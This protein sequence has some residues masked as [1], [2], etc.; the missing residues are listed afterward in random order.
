[1]AQGDQVAALRGGN[2]PVLARAISQVENGR[3]GFEALLSRIHP[4][5]GHA[6]R[7]G[8]TGPPGAG[9]STLTERLVHWVHAAAFFVLLG[10]GLCLYLPALTT[11]VARRPL[12]VEPSLEHS[13]LDQPGKPAS[14]HVR[15]D[16]Q[17][18]LKLVEPGLAGEGVAKDQDAPP[19]AHL[20]EAAGDRAGHGGEALALHGADATTVTCMMKASHIAAQSRILSARRR[21]E[22]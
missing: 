10:S 16:A 11:L 19:L 13:G 2:V 21:G 6:R 22:P 15:G 8:I 7:I 3:A 1:M 17:A 5:L 14:Q 9:K 12:A 18:L 20:L 4:T